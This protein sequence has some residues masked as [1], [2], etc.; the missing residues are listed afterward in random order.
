MDTRKKRFPELRKGQNLYYI[1]V[2]TEFQKSDD[3]KNI[4]LEVSWS[5]DRDDAVC[6]D[7]IFVFIDRV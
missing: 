2:R 7:N 1:E 4:L 3:L 6:I 5:P